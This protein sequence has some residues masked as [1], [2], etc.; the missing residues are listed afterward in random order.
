LHLIRFRKARRTSL[1]EQPTTFDELIDALFFFKKVP[2]NSKN[3][4]IFFD[5]IQSSPKI[6]SQ[7]RFFK[8]ERQTCM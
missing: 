7:L 3:V 6:V 8:E 1:C 2:K 4:L 5:E